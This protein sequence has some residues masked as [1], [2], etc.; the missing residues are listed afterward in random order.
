MSKKDKNYVE[1]DYLDSYV[2]SKKKELKRKSGIADFYDKME[3]KY[4][5]PNKKKD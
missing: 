5:N 3:K 4:G 2:D 1:D